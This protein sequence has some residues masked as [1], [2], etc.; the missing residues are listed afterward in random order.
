M[1]QPQD[2]LVMPQLALTYRQVADSLQVSERTVWSL[3]QSGQLRAV[4]IGRSV[5]IAVDELRAYLDRQTAQAT[6]LR[7][8][9]HNV[10]QETL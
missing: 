4:R 6:G 3:V 5:R 2:E 8:R 9:E 10:G 7:L 1:I